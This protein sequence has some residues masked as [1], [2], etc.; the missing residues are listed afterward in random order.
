MYLYVLS[1]MDLILVLV[2]FQF[3]SIEAIDCPTEI[4]TKCESFWQQVF[5]YPGTHVLVYI[6]TVSSSAA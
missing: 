3:K 4:D 5:K 6:S 1:K 2:L